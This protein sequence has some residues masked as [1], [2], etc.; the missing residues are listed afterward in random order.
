[1][2]PWEEMAGVF[3]VIASDRL[4]KKS[5]EVLSAWGVSQQIH[6]N[7]EDEEKTLLTFPLVV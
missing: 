4:P 1:M 6:A 5:V 7:P 2:R 3:C